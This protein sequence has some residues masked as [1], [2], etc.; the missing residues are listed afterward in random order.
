[1]GWASSVLGFLV[2]LPLWTGF[3]PTADMQFVEMQRI[4]EYAYCCG[5]GGGVPDAHPGVARSAGIQ[6]LD[7]ARVAGAEMLV[8]ACQHCRHNLTR[9][10]DGA[11]MPVID[12]V[13]LAYEAAGLGSRHE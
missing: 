7:E 13:D 1:M 4:R 8:T 9:R 12:L 2:C 6:R 3:Q 5:G 11:S 10:Q